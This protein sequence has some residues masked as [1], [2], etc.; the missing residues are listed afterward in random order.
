M[1]NKILF[2][3]SRQYNISVRKER[4]VSSTYQHSFTAICLGFGDYPK[5][6]CFTNPLQSFKLV[7]ASLIDQKIVSPFHPVGPLDIRTRT[8]AA[9][10]ELISGASNSA[11]E[12]P[13]EEVI[14]Q[15]RGHRLSDS[16]N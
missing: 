2:K 15:Q 4:R 7:V 14:L 1:N 10:L 11:W 8:L 12:I 9:Q 13:C 16:T 3:K 6:L 5:G